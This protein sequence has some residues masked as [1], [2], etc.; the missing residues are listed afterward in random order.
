MLGSFED[1]SSPTT[2]MR[3]NTLQIEL[4]ESA[5]YVKHIQ[6]LEGKL[7]TANNALKEQKA[8]YD[9]QLAQMH[10]YTIPLN[11]HSPFDPKTNEKYK[12]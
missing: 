8:Y 5:E 6:L 3:K 12:R 4:A 1:F 2:T 7:A 9:D 11:P 10:T